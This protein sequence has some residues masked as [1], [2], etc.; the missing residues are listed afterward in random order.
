L[1]DGTYE[2]ATVRVLNGK[3]VAVTA[4]TRV[5]TTPADPCATAGGDT[6]GPAT[7]ALSDDPC[8]LTTQVG[9]E[10]LTQVFAE[11]AGAT[12]VTGCGTLDDPLVINTPVPEVSGVTVDSCGVEIENGLVKAWSSFIKQVVFDPATCLSAQYN[13]TTCTITVTKIPGC[14]MGGS[15]GG[16]TGDNGEALPSLVCEES[17]QHALIG[18]PNVTY[19]L[20][21]PGAATPSYSI[22]LTA[23]GYGTLGIAVLPG[24]YE[25]RVQGQTTIL[26]S[27]A[28]GPCQPSGA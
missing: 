4:G 20:Y 19:E 28:A 5:V 17:G 10:L 13:P 9:G 2:N 1:A 6:G 26:G 24:T 15:G 23:G 22:T 8:N 16:N 21:V 11:G 7:V 14:N 25:V 12:S 18:T 3:V 27:V